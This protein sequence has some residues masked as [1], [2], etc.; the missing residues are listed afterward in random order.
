MSNDFKVWDAI[1]D[2]PLLQLCFHADV[3]SIVALRT[4]EDSYQEVCV[5]EIDL[6][7]EDRFYSVPLESFAQM[8]GSTVQE[9]RDLY[10]SRQNKP[11]GLYFPD[12][13][14]YK[15]VFRPCSFRD[16]STIRLDVSSNPRSEDLELEDSRKNLASNSKTVTA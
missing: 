12:R 7:I 5:I 15:I 2:Y 10:N 8:V 14:P 1:T 3:C 11:D 13:S 6:D 16:S 9:I 4:A